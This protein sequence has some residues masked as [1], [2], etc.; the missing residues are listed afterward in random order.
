MQGILCSIYSFK[1]QSVC[2]GSKNVL[3]SLIFLHS[4]LDSL[5]IYVNMYFLKIPS[6]NNKFPVPLA[7][8]RPRTMTE[9]SPCFTVRRKFR[10]SISI[11]DF[12]YV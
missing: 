3:I 1:I 7:A 6:I 5:N 4:V 2:L 10:I 12:L 8:T 9:S 11:F